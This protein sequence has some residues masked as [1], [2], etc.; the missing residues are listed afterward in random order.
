MNILVTILSVILLLVV[1]V[2]THHSATVQH[3]SLTCVET[4]VEKT[5]C[6]SLGRL[7]AVNRS[8]VEFWAIHFVDHSINL[9]WT[10]RDFVHKLT[11]R[12][13]I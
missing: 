2:Q 1:G 7:G 12:G 9:P 4:Q 6:I 10:L 3:V 8:G 11:M 5:D 13:S